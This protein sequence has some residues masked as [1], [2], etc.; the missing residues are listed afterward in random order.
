[1]AYERIPEHMQ[2]YL[3][4]MDSKDGEYIDII[5]GPEYWDQWNTDEVK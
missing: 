4:D 2:M 3:G 5:Y 1:M